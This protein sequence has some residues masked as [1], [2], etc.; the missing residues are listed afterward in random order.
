[1]KYLT[2]FFI[3]LIVTIIN[4]LPHKLVVF[5]GRIFG[6]LLYFLSKQRRD[7]TLTNLKNAYPTKRSK[8]ITDICKFSYQNLGISIFELIKFRTQSISEIKNIIK[9][10]NP[11]LITEVYNRG[12]G[13][14]MM[15]GHFGNWEMLALAT[16]IETSSTLQ[17]GINVVAKNQ[18]NAFFDNYIIDNREKF[19]N[20][21]INAGNAAKE[22]IKLIKNKE[23]VALI[24]DQSADPN[25]DVFVDFFGN[26]AAT[27]EAPA[28]LALKFNLPILVSY[29]I[30]QKDNT[31][32]AT[33]EELK[34]DDLLFDKEGIKELTL[35]HVKHLENQIRLHP[36]MWSWQHRR[37]KH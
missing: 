5:C 11:E 6:M 31:Y 22:M 24:V 10:T 33:F 29:A 17:H 4:L 19:G 37:W 13:L 18:K 30:R 9:F 27:Y 8:E 12:K 23:I 21:V 2:T 16:G 35:R 20:K 14:I 1:M 25:K 32:I 26:P 7:I 15:T 28:V 34:H 3:K 36:D